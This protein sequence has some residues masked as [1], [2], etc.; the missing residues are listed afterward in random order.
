MKPIVLLPLFVAMLCAGSVAAQSTPPVSKKDS[1]PPDIDRSSGFRLPLPRREDLDENGKKSFDRSTTSPDSIAGLQGP[2]G[3]QLYSPVGAQISGVNNFLRR[4]SG[5]SPRVREIAILITA[6]EMD[7]Q[8]EWT[9]HEPEGLKVG[10]PSAVIEAIKYRK[11]LD[12]LEQSD[13]ILIELGRQL[14]HDHRVK[15]DTF[16]TAKA[17][18]GPQKVVEIVMLM[19]T[20]ASTAALLTA[21][22]MQLHEGERPRLPIP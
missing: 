9:A 4:Q 14:W 12:G 18:Y 22:D 10:V 11:S 2:G 3:V 8:F 15:S 1:W 7:S 21:V 17:I 13:A 20:Y 5:I 16:A 19:G 6:R